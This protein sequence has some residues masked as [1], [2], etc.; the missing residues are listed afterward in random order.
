[1]RKRR[2]KSQRKNCDCQALDH[3]APRRRYRGPVRS[4]ERQNAY[5]SDQA[6]TCSV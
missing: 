2:D 6:T 5:V 1:L 4:H 3:E